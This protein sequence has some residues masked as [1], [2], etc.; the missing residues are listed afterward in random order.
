[1]TATE[2]RLAEI[3]SYFIDEYYEDD[4]SGTFAQWL[5][6][7]MYGDELATLCEGLFYKAL[8]DIQPV[9][10]QEVDFIEAEYRE[11]RFD[12]EQS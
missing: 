2:R 1:M 10:Q 5:A 11:T 7:C 12:D 9:S 6:Q 8:E 3:Y 4:Y